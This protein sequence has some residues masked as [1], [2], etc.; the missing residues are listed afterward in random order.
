MQ[1][2]EKKAASVFLS[3][4]NLVEFYSSADRSGFD[5]DFQNN[6]RTSAEGASF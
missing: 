3:S 5:R 4:V 1:F 2:K 6:V